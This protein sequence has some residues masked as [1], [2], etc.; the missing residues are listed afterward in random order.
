MTRTSPDPL[1][2]R[3]TGTLPSVSR[4]TQQLGSEREGSQLVKRSNCDLDERCWFESGLD[5]HRNLSRLKP[6]TES[7]MHIHDL[8]IVKIPKHSPLSKV[9]SE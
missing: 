5:A 8:E 2:L 6:I 4:A 3:Y 1:P 9:P 7:S